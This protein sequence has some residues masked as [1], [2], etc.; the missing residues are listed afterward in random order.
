MTAMR[1][2]PKEITFHSAPIVVL[3]CAMLGLFTLFRLM[4]VRYAY[5]S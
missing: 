1:S 5:D 3:R 2:K 4:Y